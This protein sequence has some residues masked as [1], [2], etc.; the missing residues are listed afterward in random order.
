MNKN[1]SIND[2]L[3]ETIL[4][5]KGQ[6]SAVRPPVVFWQDLF[7]EQGIYSYDLISAG[8]CPGV[9]PDH[10]TQFE[11]QQRDRTAAKKGEH[12]SHAVDHET[13][14][15]RAARAEMDR[16]AFHSLTVVYDLKQRKFLKEVVWYKARL[17]KA[18][19]NQ[20]YDMNLKVK[21]QR[22]C[23]IPYPYHYAKWIIA[24]VASESAW[25]RLKWSV[26][27]YHPADF[28]N[29]VVAHP[30]CPLR[31]EEGEKKALASASWM[32]VP[33]I[34]LGGISMWRLRD[35]NH[36]VTS[37][38]RVFA[39]N[40]SRIEIVF[41]TPKKEQ[42]PEELEGKQ[43]SIYLKKYGAKAVTHTT[44][45]GIAGS[46][47]DGL[48]NC[49]DLCRRYPSQ[50]AKIAKR[51]SAD[52]LNPAGTDPYGPLA[53]SRLTREADHTTSG[54]IDPQELS[55]LVSMAHAD[56]KKAV[57]AVLAAMGIGKTEAVRS[58]TA[59]NLAEWIN[60]QIPTY[61]ATLSIT[62]AEKFH[63][64]SLSGLG[65][66]VIREA[67]YPIEDGCPRINGSS[68]CG[69]SA[70]KIAVN[71]AGEIQNL[72]WLA[73]RL[74]SGELDGRVLLVLDEISQVIPNWIEGGCKNQVTNQVVNDLLLVMSHPL[75]DVIAMDALIGDIELDLLEETCQTRPCL[76]QSSMVR[77]KTLNHYHHPETYKA[78]ITEA[79]MNPK[80]K[81]FIGV[82]TKQAAL[83]WSHKAKE[84]GRRPLVVTSDTTQDR[85]LR[86]LAE[87]FMATPDDVVSGKAF[88]DHPVWSQG[89]DC[90]IVTTSVTSGLS[91]VGGD[92]NAVFVSTGYML[93]GEIA[94]QMAGRLRTC[95]EINFYAGGLA[96]EAF[97]NMPT[98][99]DEERIRLIIADGHTS[100]YMTDLTESMAPSI[101]NYARKKT[102]QRNYERRHVL[103][104]SLA[105]FQ[106]NGYQLRK[107]MGVEVSK[108]VT[109]R[110]KEQT[111][112]EL[113][114]HDQWLLR[115]LNNEA[116]E[117]DVEVAMIAE[118]F[119][120]TAA[121]KANP[122]ERF[123]QLVHIG[124]AGA[125]RLGSG[126]RFTAEDPLLNAVN[127]RY[128]AMWQDMDQNQRIAIRK[129]LGFTPQFRETITGQHARKMLEALG[130][131][132]VTKKTNRDSGYL[133]SF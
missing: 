80:V 103:G 110:K 123:R 86:R 45:T 97:S 60:I 41:D 10:R 74:R 122:L 127:A 85:A 125:I 105:H 129:E 126:H 71:S 3:R 112:R 113:T 87:Q 69:E 79:L 15:Q 27:S 7:I 133:L 4:A 1:R 16:F 73:G 55:M 88:P 21:D 115:L 120:P 51:Y 101:K 14:I 91:M 59:E 92:L 30:E 2:A 48:V 100:T 18:R 24:S 98:S 104:V 40:R 99:D 128:L 56:G 132:V 28:W 106:S 46:T 102:Q 50:A 17:K 33:I 49:A 57:I 43:L 117:A 36:K 29:W 68:Y 108:K 77:P 37:S 35:N 70:L 8:L 116:Q 38:L 93:D 20:R 61:R 54:E 118:N 5:A 22:C 89:F 131:K 26:S 130:C 114:F 95:T 124:L 96:S 83:D 31:F 67:L 81:P 42:K 107:I 11:A 78:A 90:L 52:I 64:P 34:A 13:S 111:D 47:D 23:F 44:L 109:A 6:A 82:P 32:P 39:K 62:Y 94:V 75:V 58:L 72:Q 9:S 65:D 66:E 25:K 76:Y 63:V 121:W 12:H 53:Y 19:G 119:G 84:L